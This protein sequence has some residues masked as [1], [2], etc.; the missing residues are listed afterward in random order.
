MKIVCLLKPE[1]AYVYTVKICHPTNQGY[2]VGDELSF[3]FD[4]NMRIA[5]YFFSS[6]HM[7]T[8]I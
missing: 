3:L 1:I 5:Y 7:N 6:E 4:Y 8:L 2:E